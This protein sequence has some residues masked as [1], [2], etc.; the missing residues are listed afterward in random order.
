MKRFLRT[1]VLAALLAPAAVLATP[2]DINT[3]DATTLESVKGIG[4]AKAQ[5]I[6]DYRKQH[7][8]FASTADLAKVPGIG[9]RT[10]EQIG[11]QV[12]VGAPAA[13]KA[14]AKP[15]TASKP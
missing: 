13:R 4:P 3:A 14:A 8:P 6:L 2:V 11:D 12:T 1:L 15:A 7:G 10:L 9:T 5:A